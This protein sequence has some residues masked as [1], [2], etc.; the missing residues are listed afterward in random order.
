MSEGR[1]VR[2]IVKG[3]NTSELKHLKAVKEAFYMSRSQTRQELSTT[4][5]GT[6]Y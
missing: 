2:L 4:S 1:T 3:I 5:E 6:K